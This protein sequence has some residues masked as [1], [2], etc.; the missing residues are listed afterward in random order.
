[1]NAWH[2][3]WY[4]GYSSHI[5]D[6][7]V[8]GAATQPKRRVMMAFVVVVDSWRHWQP[9]WFGVVPLQNVVWLCCKKS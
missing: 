7:A 1:M 2:D 3:N 4:F 8:S 5:E 9:P 6:D